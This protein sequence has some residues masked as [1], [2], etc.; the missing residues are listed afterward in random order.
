MTADIDSWF[1]ADGKADPCAPFP[2]LMWRGRPYNV[3]LS[4]AVLAPFLEARRSGAGRSAE[5]VRRAL[6]DSTE[7]FRAVAPEAARLGDAAVLAALTVTANLQRTV[8]RLAREP[9]V[10]P[11]LSRLWCGFAPAP[12]RRRSPAPPRPPSRPAAPSDLRPLARALRCSFAEI[13]DQCDS[14]LAALRQDIRSGGLFAPEDLPRL[15][16][17]RRYE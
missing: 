1:A 12:I 15:P 9:G 7:A 6:A 8:E 14:A 13:E 16:R 3:A 5:A 2:T 4:E 17:R 10:P 11:P